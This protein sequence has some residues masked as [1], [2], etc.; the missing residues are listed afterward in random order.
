MNSRFSFTNKYRSDLTR[1]EVLTRIDDLLRSKS[2]FLFF[3]RHQYFGEVSEN[4]FTLIR[5]KFDWWGMMSSRLKG[6]MF[7]EGGTIIRT[8]IT[9][10]WAIVTI[11]LLV[12]VTALFAIVRMR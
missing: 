11:F 7:N 3:S 9:I 6:R 1:E 12:T 8:R 5:Q 2:K 4:E 10:P